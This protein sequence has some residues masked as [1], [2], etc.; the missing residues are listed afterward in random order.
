M[1]VGK[2]QAKAPYNPIF[3]RCVL[4]RGIGA[5]NGHTLLYVKVGFMT[6][7]FPNRFNYF[8]FLRVI[9]AR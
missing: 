9:V 2:A 1:V 6:G 4:Q 5:L 7:L 8:S 3:F